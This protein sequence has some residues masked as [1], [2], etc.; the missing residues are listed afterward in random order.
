MKALKLVKSLALCIQRNS[1]A[2]TERFCRLTMY[3]RSENIG[4]LA[5]TKCSSIIE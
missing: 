4:N 1:Y 3:A 5:Y 2:N